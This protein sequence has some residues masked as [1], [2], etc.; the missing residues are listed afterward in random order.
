MLETLHRAAFL[1]DRDMVR[2]QGAFTMPDLPEQP[3]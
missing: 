3:S 2:T 1:T